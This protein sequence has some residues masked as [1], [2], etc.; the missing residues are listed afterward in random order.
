MDEAL[1]QLRSRGITAA[2][3]PCHVGSADQLKAFV[4]AAVKVCSRHAA[5]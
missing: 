5:S 4:Q 2:G 3:M 1:Q